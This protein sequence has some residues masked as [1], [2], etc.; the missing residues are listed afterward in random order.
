ME[1]E[2]LG[3]ILLVKKQWW[4]KVIYREDQPARCRLELPKCFGEVL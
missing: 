3:T 4:L 1:K 2:T